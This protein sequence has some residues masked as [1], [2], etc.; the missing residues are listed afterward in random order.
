MTEAERIDTFE[1]QLRGNRRYPQTLIEAFVNYLKGQSTLEAAR[2]EWQTAIAHKRYLYLPFLQPSESEEHL[3]ALDLRALDLY[4][5]TQMSSPFLNALINQKRIFEAFEYLLKQGITQR[6]ILGWALALAH[7]TVI[8]GQVSAL[9]AYLLSFVPDQVSDLLEVI[10]SKERYEQNRVYPAFVQL[11]VTAQPPYIDL[12]WQVAQ[13]VQQQDKDAPSTGYYGSN[14]L[15][16]VVRT[17]LKTDPARFTPWA[18]ELAR[19]SSAVSTHARLFALQAL[20]Q[21]NTEQHID[22]ALEAA[23]TPFPSQQR[24]HYPQLQTTGL[25]A[26]IDFDAAKYW[27][28]LE[29]ATFSP[30]YYLSSDAIRILAA[31]N[32]DQARPTLQ[33]CV[34]S[35]SA[36]IAGQALAV[37]LK[38]SWEGQTDYALTLLAHRSKGI[39][40]QSR[41][42]LVA[43]G[44]ASV[45]GISPYLTHRRADARL[46][47]VLA[48]AQIG[49]QRA[50]TLLAARLDAEQ[51]P[52]VTAA[53][54][55]AVGVPAVRA[56][57]Q[58]GSARSAAALSAEA[59]ATLRYVAPAT[60]AWFDLQAAPALCWT[61]GTPVPQ[62][63]LSYLLYRQSRVQNKETLDAQV[64]QALPLI[65][66]SASGDLALALY[67]GWKNNGAASAE[68]W[69]LPLACALGDARLATRLRRQIED[70]AAGPR[71]TLAVQGI[72]ALARIESESA[73][74]ELQTLA[75]EFTRGSMKYTLRKAVAVASAR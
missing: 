44:Q 58:G 15:G 36:M 42:W 21:Q 56:A 2:Q 20:L 30:N 5:V 41:K 60:L 48:L 70:W 28:L 11:L 10:E 17:L 29:A 50:T 26:L 6:Q 68:S 62:S 23:Q 31:A 71:R 32:A 18:R 47:A 4:S 53:M 40:D 75:K 69:L 13:Q 9:G 61:D 64:S 33:R 51:T 24:Y 25:R 14:A 59:E 7:N 65:D 66:R 39:R 34:A 16:A 49:G 8:Q 22:L 74:T 63:V 52:R 54:L 37:L 35:G 45:E 67:R 72:Q 46:A 27:P 73:L 3:D 1:Q 57:F 38:Q 55:D 43:Q 12:A 19:P